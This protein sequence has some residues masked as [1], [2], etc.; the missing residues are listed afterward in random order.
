M[1]FPHFFGLATTWIGNNRHFQRSQTEQHDPP[2]T[3]DKWPY[4]GRTEQNEGLRDDGAGLAGH[5]CSG[6]RHGVCRD[7]PPAG[8]RLGGEGVGG[9]S[10]GGRGACVDNYR[11]VAILEIAT[12]DALQLRRGC[13]QHGRGRPLLDR[14]ERVHARSKHASASL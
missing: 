3:P 10:T 2:I 6:T 5:P 1:R 14:L 12:A 4:W 7:L 11:F 13:N 8:G 9:D